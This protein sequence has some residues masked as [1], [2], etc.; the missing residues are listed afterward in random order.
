MGKI[1][2]FAIGYILMATLAACCVSTPFYL[3]VRP[4]KGHDAAAKVFKTV[5]KWGFVATIPVVVIL[6]MHA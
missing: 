1:I 3:L 6:A 2:F 5:F 4:F